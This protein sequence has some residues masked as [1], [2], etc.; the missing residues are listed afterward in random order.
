[1]PGSLARMTRKTPN[2]PRRCAA[3]PHPCTRDT[4]LRGVREVKAHVT[5]RRVA[6][7]RNTPLRGM[8]EVKTHAAARR[9]RCEDTHRSAVW[10]GKESAA[11]RRVTSGDTRRCA[12]C[13][14][15]VT[16]L[17]GVVG[18]GSSAS[19][20][21]VSKATEPNF[22]ARSMLHLWKRS[23]LPLRAT[24]R[25]YNLPRDAHLRS[26]PQPWGLRM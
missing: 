11:A 5:A 16:P 8:S 1:M 20:A 14:K 3:L 6:S 13:E 15:Y 26:E 21:Q 7:K 19:S 23:N 9:V 12:A 17:R 2:R 18:W 22:C 24:P 4:P 10:Q 25:R